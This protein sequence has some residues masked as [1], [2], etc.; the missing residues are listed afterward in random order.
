MAKEN[1]RSSYFGDVVKKFLAH[2]LAMMGTIVLILEVL[3]VVFL[4]WFFRNYPF[5]CFPTYLSFASNKRFL[6]RPYIVRFIIFNRLFVPSTKP[7]L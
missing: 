2:R 5:L 7:L 3:A 6:Q 1:N 4:P